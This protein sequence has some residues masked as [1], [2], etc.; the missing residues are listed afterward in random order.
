MSDTLS[1]REPKSQSLS[2]TATPPAPSRDLYE[3]VWFE[4]PAMR[5][6]AR[7]S[8]GTT[9]TVPKA[10]QGTAPCRKATL[11]AL[12]V[13]VVLAMT[14]PAASRTPE[15]GFLN[16]DAIQRLVIEEAMATPTVPPSLALAV[17]KVESNFRSDALSAAG[18]RG[19]MQIMPATARGEFGVEPDELWDTR[20]NIQ[21]GIDF[22][23]RLIERYKG[24]W[25][26]ALSHY[27]AGSI[28]GTLPQA[29]P[30]PVARPYVE[31]VLSWEKWYRQSEAITRMASGDTNRSPR[32]SWEPANTRITASPRTV[33]P[34]PL[35][36]ATADLRPIPP[37]SPLPQVIR[38]PSV[39]ASLPASRRITVALDDFDSTIAQRR[40]E[41][42]Q[43]LDDFAPR[44]RW[45]P[46]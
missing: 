39:M 37:V 13:A 5:N 46:G 18:A 38:S 31:A 33:L 4:G 28:S 29:G 10:K 12:T 3:A 24:R 42:R 34:R 32:D 15:V 17:A 22:L 21:L 27:N 25:D 9:L 16:P 23:G 41:A 19:V 2:M 44:I 40:L 6:V 8:H 26:L 35:P 11:A 45:S 30:L 20:L 43:R 36:A 7:S 14:N 1:N